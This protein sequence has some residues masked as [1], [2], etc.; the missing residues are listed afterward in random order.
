MWQLL[1]LATVMLWG[2][3]GV[4][5]KLA[6]ASLDW[7]QVYIWTSLASPLA[8]LTV[9]IVHQ[10]RIAVS[11]ASLLALTAGVMGALGY[12]SFVTAVKVGKASLVVPLTALYPAVTVVA[13]RVILGE[14]MSPLQLVGII[15]AIVSAVLISLEPR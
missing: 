15:L 12:I 1:A 2:L 14:R 4:L 7:Q 6:S 9:Y 5:I 8:A 3:W 13:S 10:P 11:E